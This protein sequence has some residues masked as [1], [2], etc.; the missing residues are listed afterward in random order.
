MQKGNSSSVQRELD[1][2]LRQ[3]QALIS[4]AISLAARVRGPTRRLI[5]RDS[6]AGGENTSP[7]FALNER[8][9][10]KRYARDVVGGGRKF[11]V[12]M[13]FLAK[14]DAKKD[15][16]VSD[17]EQL[18]NRTSSQSLIGMKFNRKFPT[19]A[20]EHGWVNSRKRGFYNLEQS[21]KDV[22]ANG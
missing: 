1:T 7:S 20:K 18:W 4:D 2:K 11:V 15:V 5:K 9:F 22:F 17:L 19:I 13:A 16:A 3:A 8:A 21:W 6:Q 12:L 10:V 14:G